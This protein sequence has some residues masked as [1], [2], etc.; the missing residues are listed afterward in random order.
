MKLY[1]LLTPDERLKAKITD[2][3]NSD[4]DHVTV[5]ELRELGKFI[6]LRHSTDMGED[7]GVNALSELMERKTI[8]NEKIQP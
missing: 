2:V 6:D 7:L 1:D 5:E 8:N 4:F 3:R